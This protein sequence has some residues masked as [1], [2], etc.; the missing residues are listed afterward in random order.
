M[1]FGR[2]GFEWKI[3]F[4]LKESGGPNG[5]KIVQMINKRY[6]GHLGPFEPFCTNLQHWQTCHVWPLLIKIGQFLLAILSQV[7]SIVGALFTRL[8][9]AVMPQKREKTHYLLYESVR[10][11]RRLEQYCENGHISMRL[12]RAKIGKLLTNRF[13]REQILYSR[14]FQGQGRENI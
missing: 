5:T 1:L 4:C 2:S 8:N 9:I 12:T 14:R 7:Y 10:R 6:I 3:N 13:T 11:R